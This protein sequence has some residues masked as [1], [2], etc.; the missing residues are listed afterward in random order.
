MP[1]SLFKS[2][3]CLGGVVFLCIG[4]NLGEAPEFKL[5]LNSVEL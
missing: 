5:D 3:L 4:C 1:Y 2:L